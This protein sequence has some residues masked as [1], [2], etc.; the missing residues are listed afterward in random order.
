LRIRQDGWLDG[1]MAFQ[2]QVDGMGKVCS[3]I[4]AQGTRLRLPLWMPL[5]ML[6]GLEHFFVRKLAGQQGQFKADLGGRRRCCSD[7]S[8]RLLKVCLAAGSRIS[9][10][11]VKVR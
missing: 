3:G 5:W 11:Q 6:Q 7:L 4:A 9:K 8:R 1:W 2:V 10:T